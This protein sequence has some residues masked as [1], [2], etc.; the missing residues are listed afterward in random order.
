MLKRIKIKKFLLLGF[1]LYAIVSFVRQEAS[2]RAIEEERAS[3][4]EELVQIEREVEELQDKIDNK[5]NI[6][7]IEKIARDE[8]DMVRPNEIIYQDAEKAE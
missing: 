3:K 2:I 7:Y 8:L 6:E 5:E 1:C 4:Q